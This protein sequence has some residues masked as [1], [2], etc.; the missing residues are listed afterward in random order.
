MITI[1]ITFHDKFRQFKD[2]IIILRVKFLTF[3]NFQLMEYEILTAVV[4]KNSIL[5]Y[6]DV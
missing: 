6:N 4:T 1:I 3:Q 2:G 5:G